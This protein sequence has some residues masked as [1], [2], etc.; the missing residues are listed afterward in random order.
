MIRVCLLWH[1]HQ[2]FYKDLVSRQY[3]MPWARLHALKDYFGMVEMT[4]EFPAL[5]LT[6][7]LAPSLIAQIED[8]ATGAAL[9]AVLSV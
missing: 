9:G 1:M 4:R 7:N 3:R 8:Y 6:F 5:R 2:P